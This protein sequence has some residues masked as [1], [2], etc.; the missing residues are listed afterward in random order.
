MN[1]H[2]PIP[3]PNSDSRITIFDIIQLRV[4]LN[5][6]DDPSPEIK[7]TLS[8]LDTIILSTIVTGKP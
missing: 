8:I 2:N 7:E 1:N 5:I 3:P 4:D 6:I